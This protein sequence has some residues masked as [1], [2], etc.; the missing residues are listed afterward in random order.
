[1][2]GVV[3]SNR[4]G[5]AVRGAA[6]CGLLIMTMPVAL[7]DEPQ[8]ADNQWTMGGQN[9]RDWR[10]QDDTGISPQNAAKLKTKWV[11]T[12]GGDVSA[13]P[14]VANGV[15][16]FPDFAGNFYAVNA[17]TGALVWKRQLADWTGVAG[18]FARSYP[19]V[20]QGMVILG[21]QAGNNAFWSSAGN[22]YIGDGAKVIAVD[23]RTGNK[24]WVTQV[25]TFPTAVVTSSPVVYNGAVYVGIASAEEASARVLGTACCFSRGSMVALDL[26]T[27]HMLWQTYM[28]P[29]NGGTTGGYS[30]G[31][32]WSSTPVI[33]PKRNSVYVGT[34]NNYSVPITVE[35]CFALNNNNPNC[36]DPHDYFDSV[37]AFDLDTG[38][39][40]WARRA[41]YYDAWNANCIEV[42]TPPSFTLTPGTGPNCPVPSG[43]D[44]D[45]GTGPN[46]FSVAVDGDDGDRDGR[47][48]ILGI[49]EKSGIY[50]ALT[51]ND[52]SVVWHTQVG[53]GSILGGIEWGSAVDGKRIYV[54]ITNLFGI[55]YQ[56]Q[57]SGAW[58]NGGSWAALDPATG[59]LLWQTPTPG[60]CSPFIP[61]VAQGCMAFAPVSVANG[62]MFGGS[63]DEN[64]AGPT[65][66]ALDAKTG[67]IVWSFVTGSSV[68]A[69]P[70]IVGNS[71]YWGSGYGRFGPT[72]GTPNNKL[73][74]FSIGDDDDN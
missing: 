61:N 48:D 63:M 28:V 11:F 64:P 57:P 71:V 1:M 42:V 35:S 59:K 54:Q 55:P 31:G 13:T 8:S 60:A 5:K 10:N 58:V 34:G 70:A 40:K 21:D 50:W 27:G 3:V 53:P 37:V 24:I 30:G 4:L 9:L 38:K 47:R 68:A 29:D 6:V 43:P 52:G 22:K 46:L 39:V 69:G 7:A 74:A 41:M 18:N 72:V 17:K 12:T 32:I 67:K 49:G 2:S 20:H 73:F 56:L 66:F 15:V 33:D 36:T 23:A 62:V 25:E 14:A 19:V 26:R 51:P 45:F 44:A 65:M 16:Y